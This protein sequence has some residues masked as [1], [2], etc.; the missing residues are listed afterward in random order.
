MDRPGGTR[1][2]GREPYAGP[3]PAPV[4]P[5]ETARLLLRPLRAEDLDD[6]HAYQA[7]EDVTR[8]LY[9]EPH[10]REQSRA[11]LERAMRR[12]GLR[13]PGDGLVLAVVPHD[14]GRVVGQV[15][16]ALVSAEHRQGETGFVLHPG[17]QG[18]G[19]ATEAAAVM[20][21]LAFDHYRLHRVAGRCDPR[22]AGSIAVMRRLGMRQEAHFV[23]NEV[24]KGQ[25]GDEL[26]FAVLEHEWRSIRPGT[27][28]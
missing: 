24:F 10:D 19:Y 15:S 28:T 1:H 2:R 7:R 6:V 5:I 16:L 27:G 20:L 26:V 12:D 8:Y 21:D 25:W 3:V 23:H 17:Y 4:V 14:V 11:A 18:R 9:W 13:E 22:N